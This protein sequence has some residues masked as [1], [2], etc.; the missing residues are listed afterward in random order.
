MSYPGSEKSLT[1]KLEQPLNT[2][3]YETS[4]QLRAHKMERF[5]HIQ[6]VSYPYTHKSYTHILQ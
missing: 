1:R 2:V 5:N 4:Y 6:D 3:L